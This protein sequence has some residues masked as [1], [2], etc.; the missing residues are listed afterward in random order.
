MSVLYIFAQTHI[1]TTTVNKDGQVRY[2]QRA[3][4]YKCS[5]NMS[6]WRGKGYNTCILA[7]KLYKERR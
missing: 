1:Q 2:S 6:A 5:K 3:F 7:V 4:E